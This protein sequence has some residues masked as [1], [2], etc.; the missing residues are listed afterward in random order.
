MI[1]NIDYIHASI[2]SGPFDLLPFEI[3]KCELDPASRFILH[4][5]LQRKPFPEEFLKIVQK[6]IVRNGLMYYFWDQLHKDEVCEW[7]DGATRL[8]SIRPS[9]RLSLPREDVKRFLDQSTLSTISFPKI[10]NIERRH[11]RGRD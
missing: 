11:V 2:M 1:H 9:A 10:S 8:P 5:T 7:A 6:Y 3:K 4:H